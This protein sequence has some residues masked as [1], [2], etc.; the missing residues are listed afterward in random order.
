VNYPSSTG[1]SQ[2]TWWRYAKAQR[3]WVGLNRRGSAQP[4]LR[5]VDIESARLPLFPLSEQRRIV[6]KLDSLTSRSAR[7][8]EELGRIPRLI[9]KYREA[10]LSAAFS[11]EPTRQR[12]REN[13]SE[14][15][16]RD[17]LATVRLQRKGKPKLARQKS[18]EETP[19][20]KLPHTWEWAPQTMTTRSELDRLEATFCS[21]IIEI[22]GSDLSLSETSDASALALI[23]RGT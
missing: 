14:L 21:L 23:M 13:P 7:A 10:I 1:P 16:S 17:A 5:T 2:K 11:G 4:H 15:A 9:Q 6:S 8:R 20:I 18:I 12:R 3:Y 22:L 19:E